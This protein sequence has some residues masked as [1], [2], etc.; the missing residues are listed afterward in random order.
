M[1]R[2]RYQ[3]IQIRLEDV[4]YKIEGEWVLR[5][6][7]FTLGIG[8]SF[9]VLGRNGSGKTTLLKLISGIIEPSEGRIFIDENPVRD[10][11]ELLEITGYVFQNPQTQVVGATVEEDVAFGLENMGMERKKMQER[12]EEVLKAV[13]LWRYKE[14]DPSLLSGG[15]LQRLA[16]ASIIALDPPFLLLD[17]PLSML[18][19]EGAK[20]VVDLIK[21][22]SKERGILIATH[23]PH[24]FPF[25]NDAV[26]LESGIM[27]VEKGNP[28]VS[29]WI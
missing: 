18:D 24:K 10:R 23:E 28:V 1:E 26:H 20:E 11:G 3:D 14:F 2:R 15:Q 12:V 29:D 17:E 21:R 22:L 5:N 4:G 27:R 13:N 19:P 8:D 6:I 9:L 16:I 25:I 7:N